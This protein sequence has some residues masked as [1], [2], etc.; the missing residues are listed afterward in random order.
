[1]KPISNYIFD[2][3]KQVSTLLANY[4]ELKIN[5]EKLSGEKIMLLQKVENLEAEIKELK[6]RVEVVDVVQGMTSKDNVSNFA[7]N[8]VNGLIREIDKCISLLNE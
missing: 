5:K 7:R 2:L 8:K 6:K 1:M 4:K 3:R